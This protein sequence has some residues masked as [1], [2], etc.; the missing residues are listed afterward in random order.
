MLGSYVLIGLSNKHATS[1]L[2]PYKN[3]N[4]MQIVQTRFVFIFLSPSIHFEVSLCRGYLFRSSVRTS[5][6]EQSNS[7]ALHNHTMSALLNKIRKGRKE[8]DEEEAAA[9]VTQRS[10]RRKARTTRR[11]TNN[12]PP[13]TTPKQSQP[14]KSASSNPVGGPNKIEAAQVR[15][16]ESASLKSLRK[17]RKKTAENVLQARRRGT[18]Q[19]QLVN[20]TYIYYFI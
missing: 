9:A 13:P 1:S 4:T 16:G 20:F 18:G 14:T 5:E 17:N 2:D 7:S 15:T 3:L 6:A 12:P 8:K 19:K 10:I 11:R